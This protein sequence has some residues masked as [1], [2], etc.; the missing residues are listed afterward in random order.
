MGFPE[1]LLR[2][3][4]H[5]DSQAQRAGREQNDS[6]DGWVFSPFSRPPPLWLSGVQ[7]AEDLVH[8]KG[9]TVHPQ[10]FAEQLSISWGWGLEGV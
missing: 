7:C 6:C 5:R 9:R 3:Q 4:S 1:K 8:G 10:S 2:C